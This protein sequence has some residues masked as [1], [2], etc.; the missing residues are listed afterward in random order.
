MGDKRR[1]GYMKIIAFS[2]IAG[3][4][5]FTSHAQL[6]IRQFS[7]VSV[8]FFETP[9]DGITLVT[10][11]INETSGFE[12]VFRQHSVTYDDPSLADN[13]LASSQYSASTT[14][15][16]KIGS[17]YQVQVDITGQLYRRGFQ[18][19]GGFGMFASAEAI[20]SIEVEFDL[21]I[22]YTSWDASYTST[23]SNLSTMMNAI[24]YS[25]NTVISNWALPVAGATNSTSGDTQQ[26]SGSDNI[27]RINVLSDLS[28][29]LIQHDGEST[30]N[31]NISIV[32]VVSD[33]P[34]PGTAA[35][36]MIAG[37][38]T[39]RRRR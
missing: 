17:F 10:D 33:I 8:G 15:L 31:F 3:T 25:Q 7:E 6:E 28:D 5:S 35:L 38:L 32:G 4:C 18:T 29:V 24:E 34:A 16:G 21:G 37:L 23:Q 27:A 2:I 30:V 9:I 26:F 14:M 19:G 39:A 20:S 12:S 22:L 1:I 11:T 13:P 36:P